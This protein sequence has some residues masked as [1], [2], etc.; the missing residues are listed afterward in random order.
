MNSQDCK[1]ARQRR[2]SDNS[3]TRRLAEADERARAMAG[4]LDRYVTIRRKDR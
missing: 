4:P 2:D 1:N 3:L